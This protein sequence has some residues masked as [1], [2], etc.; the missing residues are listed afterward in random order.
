VHDGR[1]G[2]LAP[3]GDAIALA[4]AIRELSAFP[5]RRRR[6]G[7]AARAAALDRTWARSF[8]ELT[9]AYRTVTGLN[10]SATG[11]RIAA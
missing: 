9:H 2:L 3:P 10:P 11:R 8:G 1:T 7:E 5:E 6:F 4:A